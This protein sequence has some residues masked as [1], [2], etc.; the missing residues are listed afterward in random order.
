M[1]KKRVLTGLL[2]VLLIVA[3]IL[4]ASAEA[5]KPY[6][7]DQLGEITEDV[8]DLNQKATDLSDTYG[9]NVTCLLLET[10][11]GAG[12]PAVGEQVYQANF[13]ESDGI[14]LI[15]SQDDN[16]WFLYK[17]GK[18]EDLFQT[19]DED[20]LWSAF[21]GS[22]Y[23]D[24]CVTAYLDEAKEQL[25]EK[26][27][28]EAAAGQESTTDLERVIPDERVR[29]RV[30]DEAELLSAEE[31]GTLLEKLDE[32]SE[33]QKCDVVVATVNSLEGK[34]AM[35][36]AD[37]F[38]DYNGYGYGENRN[39]ILLLI[40]MED[41]DWW[42]STCG[43]GI[44]A[45]TDAGQEYI[46][47]RFRPLL[48]DG[49][50]NGAF[51]KYADLCDAF[52]TQARTGEPYDSGHLP[53]DSVSP[54]WIFGDLAI[55]FLIAFFMGSRKKAK[56]KSVRKQVA[57]QDYTR[58]GSMV[59]AAQSDYMVNRTVTSRII[60]RDDDHSGGGSSTHSSS[61]G[62]THGGSGGKF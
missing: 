38:Y 59:V 33:R 27:G 32:I 12:T 25:A 9:V 37:D 23:Y 17:S 19:E 10:T 60:P 6:I 14:M 47:D 55:G 43:Y 13:G 50:Y 52:I 56:L 62:T 26:L 22:G 21:A 57:A 58:P 51:T 15:Y 34:T 2:T 35:E 40:S 24:E 11:E 18:A 45:F 31:E 53:K 44:T 54:F 46:A 1:M 8:S 3:M 5:G 29:D 48:S 49:D 36:Y 42:I 7:V 16:E 30:V 61:S 4:P 41:R 39:G 28:A 20:A